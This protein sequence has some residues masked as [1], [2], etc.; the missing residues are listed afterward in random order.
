M[1][2]RF[3]VTGYVKVPV[4]TWLSANS[5]E[6][7][8]RQALSRDVVEIQQAGRDESTWDTHWAPCDGEPADEVIEIEADPA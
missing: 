4:E 1:S 5:R 7:A 3:R 6:E 2:T 8:V